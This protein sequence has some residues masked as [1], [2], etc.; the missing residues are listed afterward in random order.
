[1]KEIPT[2]VQLCFV[3]LADECQMQDR[4]CPFLVLSPILN[5]FS[6]FV[7]TINSSGIP[8]CQIKRCRSTFTPFCTATNLSVVLFV[9]RNRHRELCTR[10]PNPFQCQLNFPC[11]CC[12]P[13]F[14]ALLDAPCASLLFNG[15]MRRLSAKD[16]AV[17]AKRV[18]PLAPSASGVRSNHQTGN[19]NNNRSALP[20][21]STTTICVTAACKTF[22]GWLSPRLLP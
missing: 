12:C 7:S 2:S 10:P 13:T 9:A 19:N 11:C 20:P 5:Q 8:L 4:P 22:L 18:Q 14:E 15:K 6:A 3:Q 1:M 16:I 21:L 17:R